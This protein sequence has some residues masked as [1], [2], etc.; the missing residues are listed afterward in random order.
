MTKIKYILP[1]VLL[2]ATGCGAGQRLS[3]TTEEE[4]PGYDLFTTFPRDLE[5]PEHITFTSGIIE[6]DSGLY[7]L[8]QFDLTVQENPVDENSIKLTID[9][10]TPDKTKQRMTIYTVKDER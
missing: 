5:T 9:V 2:F 6:V 1:L 8:Q 4:W 3:S 10:V 7:A